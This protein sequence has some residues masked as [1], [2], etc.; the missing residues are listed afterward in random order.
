M[1]RA[2]GYTIILR[3]TCC[4]R[5]ERC[6]RP[7][8]QRFSLH[9]LMPR[10]LGGLRPPWGRLASAEAAGQLC[11]VS[12]LSHVEKAKHMGPRVLV[13]VRLTPRTEGEKSLLS[14]S[15]NSHF[16]L[17]RSISLPAGLW[18]SC[19]CVPFWTR[20]VAVSHCHVSIWICPIL[21]GICSTLTTFSDWERHLR[22]CLPPHH[23]G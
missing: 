23:F 4:H 5:L 9:H 7:C 21:G 2:W 19:L 16:C 22:R 20:N 12:A 14:L 8:A 3:G 11:L 15:I 13:L 18:S 1:D 17:A 6:L 10:A